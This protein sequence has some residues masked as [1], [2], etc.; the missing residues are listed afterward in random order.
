[1]IAFAWAL[2]TK[3]PLKV[4]V[5]R[6]R[7]TLAREVED[8]RIENVFRL[9]IMNT[10]EEPRRFAIGVVGLEGIEIA[11]DKTVDIPAATTQSVSVRVRAEPGAGSRGSN[12]ILFEVRAVGHEDV[13]VREKASFLLP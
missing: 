6:D 2:A 13:F 3:V 4:D 11:S 8:G 10:A 5:I 9:Q 1:M 12:R 7:A